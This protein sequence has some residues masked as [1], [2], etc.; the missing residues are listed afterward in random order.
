VRLYAWAGNGCSRW[1]KLDNQMIKAVSTGAKHLGFWTKSAPKADFPDG[2]WVMTKV[3]VDDNPLCMAFA[4]SASGETAELFTGHQDGSIRNWVASAHRYAVEK[5]HRGGVTQVAWTSGG[6]VSG[7]VDCQLKVWRRHKEQ[8]DRAP[9]MMLDLRAL[10]VSARAG[11]SDSVVPKSIDVLPT[12]DILLGTSSAHILRIKPVKKWQADAAGQVD[13]AGVVT[14]LLHSHYRRHDGD[15]VQGIATFP[16]EGAVLG[17]EHSLR[18]TAGCHLTKYFATCG[19]DGTWRMWHTGNRRPVGECAVEVRRSDGLV[20]LATPSCIDIS[21]NGLLV[22]VGLTSGGWGLYMDSGVSPPAAAASPHHHAGHGRGVRHGEAAPPTRW[23]QI[24]MTD[25]SGR[26]GLAAEVERLE[27]RLCSAQ[28]DA[29]VAQH[30]DMRHALKQQMEDKMRQAAGRDDYASAMPI[31]VVRFAPNGSWLAVASR[32]A[33]VQ[34]FS[35]SGLEVRVGDAWQS[36]GRL[37]LEHH[38]LCPHALVPPDR[39]ALPP[40]DGRKAEATTRRKEVVG[41][42]VHLVGMRGKVRKV[43]VCSG[44]ANAVTHCDWSADCSVLRTTSEACELLFWDAPRG[45]QHAR[46]DELRDVVWASHTVPFGWSVQGIWPVGGDGSAVCGVDVS[47]GT[48]DVRVCAT[49]DVAGHL[50]LFRYPCVGEKAAFKSYIGHASHVKNLTF[51]QDKRYVISVGGHDSSVFQWRYIPKFPDTLPTPAN[52]ADLK[53]MAVTAPRFDRQIQRRLRVHQSAVVVRLVL[54]A[55]PSEVFGRQALFAEKLQVEVSDMLGASLDHVMVDLSLSPL[56]IADVTFELGVSGSDT[57]SSAAYAAALI[58]LVAGAYSQGPSDKHLL[59]N[60]ISSAT[61]LTHLNATQAGADRAS[62]RDTADRAVVAR[63]DKA[64]AHSTDVG[65]SVKLTTDWHEVDDAGAF[66]RHVL[67]DIA[68]AAGENE[69]LAKRAQ[70]LTRDCRDAEKLPLFF[71]VKS[72]HKERD[73][74]VVDLKFINDPD[75]QVAEP[76]PRRRH[77]LVRWRALAPRAAFPPCLLACSCCARALEMQ[78]MLRTLGKATPGALGLCRGDWG[79]SGRWLARLPPPS[80]PCDASL[81]S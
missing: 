70:G 43:G 5:A 46:A 56:V 27:Q 42:E 9:V 34:I 8:L 64:E 6:L 25:T 24:Y 41:G 15:S 1:G 67:L 74:L 57:A 26:Q 32:D 3:N 68:R 55:D 30:S 81:R 75:A 2:E 62:K 31:S 17:Q 20:T 78:Q 72:V 53:Q 50:K 37:D 36:V 29:F 63:F 40:S 11:M 73:A 58:K 13:P 4:M 44:H 66:G 49:G 71:A 54:D 35:V 10:A 16:V 28:A 14:V 19:G 48:G 7:G 76:D 33:K 59:L 61:L 69:A 77:G 79:H 47:R 21:P 22:A 51:T 23:R 39:D 45:T 60:K 18:P 12:G 38:H 65:F 52:D 80:P